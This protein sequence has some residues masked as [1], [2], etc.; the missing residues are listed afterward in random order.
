MCCICKCFNNIRYSNT[1][2]SYIDYYIKIKSSR[3]FFPSRIETMSYKH[4]IYKLSS[5]PFM[6]SALF[7][8]ASIIFFGSNVHRFLYQNVCIRILWSLLGMSTM[9][10][11]ILI[12]LNCAI[13]IYI[14]YQ[15]I[16]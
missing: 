14:L 10:L 5:S 7:R 12:A 11:V 16:N 8:L 6:V 4:V 1:F 3:S 9:Q 13:P 2:Y 15:I